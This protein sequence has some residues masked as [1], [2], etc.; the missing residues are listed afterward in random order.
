MPISQ[1]VHSDLFSDLEAY[2]TGH[3]DSSSCNKIAPS[4]CDDASA[5]IL[6]SAF[7]LYN[8]KIVG[9]VSSLS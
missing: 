5:D 3:Q 1:F 7:G 6:I 2:A 9:L 8:V 4:L